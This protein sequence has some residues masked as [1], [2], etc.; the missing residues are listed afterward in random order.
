MGDLG[1]A[2]RWY[3]HGSIFLR[4]EVWEYFTHNNQELSSGHATRAGVSI[5]YSFGR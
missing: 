1:A 4:P 3:V 5:G 2:I